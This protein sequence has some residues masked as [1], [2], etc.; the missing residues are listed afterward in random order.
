MWGGGLAY[1]VPY[2]FVVK[3]DLVGSLYFGNRVPGCEYSTI[4]DVFGASK[5]S[6]VHWELELAHEVV[7]FLKEPPPTHRNRN[8]IRS[9]GHL[10]YWPP[11][12]HWTSSS[13]RAASSATRIRG[14]HSEREGGRGWGGRG[15]LM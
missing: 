12:T 11:I 2:R 4:L 13:V 9:K 14:G 5:I 7:L 10:F 1:G 3:H 15:W 6:V 8:V